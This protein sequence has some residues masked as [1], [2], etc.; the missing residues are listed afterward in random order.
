MFDELEKERSVGAGVSGEEGVTLS[1]TE[2][3][4]ARKARDIV[5]Q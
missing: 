2:R 1:Y 3:Q 5:Y 4:H